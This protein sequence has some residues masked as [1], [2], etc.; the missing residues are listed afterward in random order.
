MQ[1]ADDLFAGQFR[2]ASFEAERQRRLLARG[3]RYAVSS[4][5]P[6]LMIARD[7]EAP[8]DRPR[9]LLLLAR[10]TSCPALLLGRDGDGGA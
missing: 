1:G 6:C 3:G 8:L 2:F 10:E 7:L 5:A 4:A 9:G